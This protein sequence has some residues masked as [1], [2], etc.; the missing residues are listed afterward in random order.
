MYKAFE[1]EERRIMDFVIY[2]LG[3]ATGIALW[4]YSDIK[5]NPYIRGY[6]DGYERGFHERTKGTEE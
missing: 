4:F 6:T 2:L 3:F 1:R 5:D